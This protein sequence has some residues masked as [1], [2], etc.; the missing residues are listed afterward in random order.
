MKVL[1]I[2]KEQGYHYKTQSI[3]HCIE[4]SWS[5]ITPFQA[6][7][8]FN[9]VNPLSGFEHLPFEQALVEAKVFFQQKQMPKEMEQVNR[10]SIK[11]LQVF[12]DQGQAVIKMP[13]QELGLIRSTLALLKWDSKLHKNDNKKLEWLKK[14]PK[15]SKEIIL[16]VLS[17]LKIKE[18][19]QEMFL[20]LLLTTLPGW[21]AHALYK[22]QEANNN[23]L[24]A[25]YLA[26][27]VVLCFLIWPNCKQLLDWQVA[28]RKIADT[29]RDYQMVVE[30]EALFQKQLTSKLVLF[31]QEKK[32]VTV[33]AQLVFCID[34]RSEPFRRI[35]EEQDNYETFGAAGFFGLPVSVRSSITGDSRSSCPAIVK[36]AFH[37]MERPEGSSKQSLGGHRMLI[38]ARK[39]YQS[40]KYC[41]V[42]PFSLVETI[43]AISGFWMALKIFT[44]NGADLT[45][46]FFKG[47]IAPCH[48][49][50]PDISNIPLKD[51]IAYAKGFLEIIGLTEKF[52]PLVV[53]CGHGSTTE[54]NAYAS[55]LDC[56]ACGGNK[57]GANAST[58][59]L[60]LNDKQVRDA[61]ALDAINIPAGT[62]F[63]A[64]E[65]NT[66][67]DDVTLYTEG[68]PK[69]LKPQVHSLREALKTTRSRNS[70]LR[71]KKLGKSITS[72]TSVKKAAISSKDW[73]QVRPEWGLAGN[74]ALIIGPRSITKGVDLEGRCFLHSY[75]WEKDPTGAKLRS[76]LTG[77]VI[78]AHSINAQYFFSTYDNVAFGAGS[79]V[80]NNITGKIG[81]MQGNAS[82]LMHGLPL[83]SVY[84]SDSDPY[85]NLLRLT[86]V[87]YAPK[88]RILSVIQ[89][90]ETLQMLFR[91]GWIHLIC[92]DPNTQVSISMD[93]D[94][95]IY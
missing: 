9:A 95:F 10:E 73:A 13:M 44:P 18:H 1:E 28:A 34:V 69:N 7:K 25:D 60:I 90:E 81:A 52:A 16:L 92:L 46:R 12:F 23:S 42:T 76:I 56:G 20:T 86:V 61:L 89:K 41:F 30:N 45:K 84:K 67:T 62:F 63:L 38:L 93:K 48:L 29:C 91:N 17:Q 80:T 71:S 79:K 65:H 66:T 58:L 19:E 94:S 64:A 8:N 88:E 51:Q 27:R 85:H 5:K 33:K 22:S 14:L 54:N 21:A 2:K 40:L 32:E 47:L 37:I 3:E 83:Q 39:M 74:A 55:A 36:P 57:G 24:Q 26:L 35:L 68:V 31:G 11:W 77:P 70:F 59:S 82:D 15:D 53:F 6:L 43:G 87:L 75:Q 72:S 49:L 4:S 78:V 50:R